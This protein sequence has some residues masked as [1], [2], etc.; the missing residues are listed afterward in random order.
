MTSRTAPWIRIA[1]TA[2]VFV[3]VGLVIV[4]GGEWHG[5]IFS[6]RYLHKRFWAVVLAILLQGYLVAFAAAVLGAMTLGWTIWASRRVEGPQRRSAS[7]RR[8][9]C[10]T[11]LC[12]SWLLGTG[13]AEVG[14]LF[15]LK[16]LH[17]LPTWPRAAAHPTDEIE[18]VVIGES[19]ARGV[20]YDD[21]L[22]VG[23][24]VGRELQRVTVAHRVHVNVLAE[25]GATLE[26]M[27]QKL[28][29]LDRRPDVL[30]IYC[31]HNEFLARFPLDNRVAYYDDE[32]PRD[33]RDRWWQLVGRVSPFLTLVQESLAKQR[34]GV[35]PARG[36]STMETIVGRPAC[37]RDEANGIVVDFQRHLASI[38]ATCAR[39]GCLPVL[40]IPPGNDASDPTQSYASPSTTADVRHALFRQL[41]EIRTFERSDPVSAIAAYQKLLAQQPTHALL[42]FRLARLLENQGEYR[43]AQH[44]YVLARD[45]DGLPLRCISRLEAV[46]RSV[47]RQYGNGVVLVDGPAVL[48]A[49]SRHGIL[50]DGLFHDNVHPTLAGYVALAG[51]VIAE[52][53]TRSA[54]GWPATTP[55]P[56]LGIQ[57]CARDFGFRARDWGTV[58]QRAAAQYGQIAFL[59]VDSAERVQ[60][61]D[62]Y[63]SAAHRSTPVRPRSSWEFRG[64]GFTEENERLTACR[65]PVPTIRLILWGRRGR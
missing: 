62:R 19:S 17:R 40:I 14:A 39:I 60:W 41:T 31:G 15:W 22:S 33:R 34:V 50:D 7:R 53:K 8:A 44:H 10:W 5:A 43:E 9:M 18:L 13:V 51:A 48:R 16:W 25:S 21:W 61:R 29:G 28:A 23:Q 38:V 59:T 52:L 65:M 32:L 26:V 54:F 11:L 20:P 58:C 36:L 57:S 1:G 42:R 4:L 55:V 46:Y 56:V 2:A 30:I 24:I 27:H 37:S 49:E 6:D 63:A 12:A 3:L 45:H 35:I 64:S 47:A